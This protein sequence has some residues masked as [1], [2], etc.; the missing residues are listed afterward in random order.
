MKW[1]LISLLFFTSARTSIA[2]NHKL[3][4]PTEKHSHSGD[5]TINS[6]NSLTTNEVLN[7]SYNLTPG[8][9]KTI[10]S[11]G[12]HREYR[13]RTVVLDAGHGGK[14]SGCKGASGTLEKHLTL[15]YTLMLGDLIKKNYPD[16]RII[17]TRST[18]EFIELHERANIANR[19]KADLFLSIH[20]NWNPNSAAYGTET[21]VLG[22]HRAKDNLEVAKRENSSIFLENNYEKNYDGFDPNSP[23]GNI[24]LCMSQNAHIDQ[25]ISLSEKIES[26]FDVKRHSRSVKQAGFLVLR[27]TS[28][29]SVLVE[30]GFL[31]N[32]KEEAFMTSEEGKNYIVNSIFKGFSQYKSVIEFSYKNI[33]KQAKP[34]EKNE[35]SA[36]QIVQVEAIENNNINTSTEQVDDNPNLIKTENPTQSNILS[37]SDAIPKAKPGF[38]EYCV[39]LT[40]SSKLIT[41]KG[42]VW[43]KI[44]NIITRKENNI[45]KYQSVCESIQQADTIKNLAKSLGFKDAFICAYKDS[46]KIPLDKA[47]QMDPT[48][49]K[50]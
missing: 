4:C 28:M 23:E 34:I 44:P 10:V 20:C 18:D 29:P 48:M 39:Q 19:N 31:S 22:L 14:D 30:T 42:E 38:P 9:I 7:F 45:Y 8:D 13:I 40:T 5:C 12:D 16:I 36:P 32:A 50:N 46:Q 17:Y 3:N 2:G 43:S 15:K 1:I 33:A 25:S 6:H 47:L 41:L 24:L 27:A 21:Y 35:I 37:S 11:G 49:T 26:A